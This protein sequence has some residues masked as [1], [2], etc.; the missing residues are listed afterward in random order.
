MC[1]RC[2]K[3]RLITVSEM[4]GKCNL[5]VVGNPVR[6]NRESDI[7]Q[8]ILGCFNHHMRGIFLE[9]A[10]RIGVIHT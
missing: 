4:D 6:N 1:H 2:H 5:V 10:V 7:E 8:N 3:K 9:S